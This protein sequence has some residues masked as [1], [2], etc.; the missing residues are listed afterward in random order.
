MSDLSLLDT[1]SCMTL[2][3]VEEGQAVMEYGDVGRN[4]Y[5]IVMGEVEIYTPDP[6]KKEEFAKAVKRQYFQKEELE[7][8]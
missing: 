2:K 3:P 1:V 4:F 8:V 5:F 7:Q 6:T